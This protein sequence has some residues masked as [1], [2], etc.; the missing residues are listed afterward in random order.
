[1]VM[2]TLPTGAH[3]GLEV[4][5]EAMSEFYERCHRIGYSKTN[6]WAI[7][8][9]LP[10]KEGHPTECERQSRSHGQC[11]TA[12]ASGQNQGAA[13]PVPGADEG[14]SGTLHAQG[15]AERGGNNSPSKQAN[16]VSGASGNS[17]LA[18]AGATGGGTRSGSS[19][20][21]QVGAT[22]DGTLSGSSSSTQVGAAGDDTQSGTHRQVW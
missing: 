21:S 13:T 19:S 8:K 3:V 18:Q 22:V 9:D 14:A 12:G 20:P 17:N 10:A 4:K 1:M 7:Q 6:C 5:F 2:I 15:K 11:S 16:A